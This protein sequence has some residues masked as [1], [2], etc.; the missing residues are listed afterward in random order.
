[1]RRIVVVSIGLMLLAGCG[2]KNAKGSLSGKLTY[3]GQPVNGA[4]MT[5]FPGQF[6][7][8][9]TQDGEFR[10]SDVPPGDYK[11]V[12]EGTPGSEGPPTKDMSPA[13]LAEAREKLAGQKTPATIKFPDK[14]TKEAT[15]TLKLTVG[16][17]AQV[18][19][20]EMTD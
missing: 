11:V 13:K 15:T 2:S 20:L 5:L 12:V 18:Q 9:V 1:M 14:Y 17:G 4:K 7:I 3:K 8:P 19:N 16:A 6:P 10:T